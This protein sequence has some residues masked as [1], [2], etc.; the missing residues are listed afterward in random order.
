V[1]QTPSSS[2]QNRS[3]DWKASVLRPA[4]GAW[5]E[6]SDA[7]HSGARKLGFASL[8][9]TPLL[10]IISAGRSQFGSEQPCLPSPWDK[11]GIQIEQVGAQNFSQNR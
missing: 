8:P 11:C 1:V 4:T 9:K 2:A 10:E 7:P 3:R 6:K 5:F